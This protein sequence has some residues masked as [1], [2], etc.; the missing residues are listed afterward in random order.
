MILNGT[1][2]SGSGNSGLKT[3]KVS[4]TITTV[5][6]DMSL[7]SGNGTLQVQFGDIT[8]SAY[9]RTGIPFGFLLDISIT[10]LADGMLSIAYDSTDYEFFVFHNQDLYYSHCGIFFPIAEFYASESS[11]TYNAYI[12]VIGTNWT[13]LFRASIPMNGGNQPLQYQYTKFRESLAG[14]I[15]ITVYK[16][17]L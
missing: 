16:V 12:N 4:E 5:G 2:F 7:L 13:N 10:N 9:Q 1:N 14:K 3:V 15:N 8:D 6:D 17:V 11:N